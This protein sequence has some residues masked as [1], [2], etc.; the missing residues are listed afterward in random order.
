[1]LASVHFFAPCEMMRFTNGFMEFEKEFWLLQGLAILKHSGPTE[2]LNI[3]K[4]ILLDL[5]GIL[6]MLKRKLFSFIKKT[7][8]KLIFY[9]DV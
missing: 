5:L 9:L 2:M 8:L 6:T 3:F 1:M 4:G 7:Y